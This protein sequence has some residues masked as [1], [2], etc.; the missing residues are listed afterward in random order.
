MFGNAKNKD[1][2]T[3]IK[4]ILLNKGKVVIDVNVWAI[5]LLNNMFH[6]NSSYSLLLTWLWMAEIIMF[7]LFWHVILFNMSSKYNNVCIGDV[8]LKPRII[9]YKLGAPFDFL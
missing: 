5:S 9:Y 8:L 3:S 1:D 6:R 7:V 4:A 2:K